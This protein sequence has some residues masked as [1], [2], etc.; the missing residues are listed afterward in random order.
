MARTRGM[1]LYPPWAC[2]SIREFIRLIHNGG[3]SW[4]NPMLLAVCYRLG[5]RR[6]S[7]RPWG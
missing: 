5:D 6:V 1:D 7:V 2:Q 3:L 4:E